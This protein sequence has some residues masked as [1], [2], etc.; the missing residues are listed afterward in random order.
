MSVTLVL[1]ESD[2]LHFDS[3][4]AIANSASPSAQDSAL[5]EEKAA[6]IRRLREATLSSSQHDH[7][8]SFYQPQTHAVA[9]APL[10]YGRPPPHEQSPYYSRTPQSTQGHA[11]APPQDQYHLGS[12]P[13]HAYPQPSVGASPVESSTAQ[14]WSEHINPPSSDQQQQWTATPRHVSLSAV[15]GVPAIAETRLPHLSSSTST[16]PTPAT[17]RT[18]KVEK[19]E[20][21]ARRMVAERARLAPSNLDHASAPEE[22]SLPS[23]PL[24]SSSSPMPQT[25]AEEK[26][27]LS[28]AFPFL[29]P[30]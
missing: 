22:D 7:Q 13:S 5:S 26:V 12:A 24:G 4:K 9:S 23:Y 18:A 30:R 8:S 2:P 11:S 6:Y 15:G 17:F 29:G 1:G 19:D 3:A 20:E 16:T 28:A 10:D 27:S 21:E 14:P 25:A